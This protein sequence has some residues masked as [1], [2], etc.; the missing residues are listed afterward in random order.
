MLVPRGLYTAEWRTRHSGLH[1]NC[2]VHPAGHGA[3]VI[4]S[5]VSVSTPDDGD[6]LQDLEAFYTSLLRWEYRPASTLYFVWT[7]QRDGVDQFGD[8]N[9]RRDR[10]AL[11]RDRRE[12]N[13]SYVSSDT[14]RWE[15]SDLSGTFPHRSAE[16]AIDCYRHVVV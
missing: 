8:F 12:Q 6:L 11:F 9:F 16:R 14:A 3:W 1:G 13:G 2:S 4:R 15:M 5:H 10:L 7:Q